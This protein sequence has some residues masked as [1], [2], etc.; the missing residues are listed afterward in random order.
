M[1]LR[2]FVLLLLLLLSLPFYYYYT[3]LAVI[4]M[5]VS[6]QHG[7]G[8]TVCFGTIKEVFVVLNNVHELTVNLHIYIL[9]KVDSFAECL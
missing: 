3:F 5:C 7:G 2:D 9:D 6:D 4:L 1:H 8:F